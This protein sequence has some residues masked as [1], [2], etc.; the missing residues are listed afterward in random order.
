MEVLV[1]CSFGSATGVVPGTDL[2]GNFA[3][4]FSGTRLSSL[5]GLVSVGGGG[6]SMLAGPLSESV[7]GRGGGGFLGVIVSGRL[8]EATHVSGVGAV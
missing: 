1:G 5:E 7:S 4:F 2:G 3:P 8:P 6:G